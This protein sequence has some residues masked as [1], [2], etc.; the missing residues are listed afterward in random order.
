MSRSYPKRKIKIKIKS[1]RKGASKLGYSE[2][3]KNYNTLKKI[4]KANQEENEY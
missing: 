1:P 3:S 4:E 2:T